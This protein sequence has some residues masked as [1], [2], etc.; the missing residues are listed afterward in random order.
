M[1]HGPRKERMLTA[2]EQIDAIRSL[3][4][5]IKR[6]YQQDLPDDFNAMVKVRNRNFRRIEIQAVSRETTVVESGIVLK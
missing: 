4:G 3:L 5:L 2:A 1:P 6:I